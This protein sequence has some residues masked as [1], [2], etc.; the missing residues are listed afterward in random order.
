KKDGFII[1]ASECRFGFGKSSFRN[2][3]I[4]LKEKGTKVF[5]DSHRTS[6]TFES[7]QW[8]VQEFTKVFEKTKNILLLSSLTK[9]DQELTFARPIKSLN[10]G[11]R[12]ATKSIKDPFIVAI[13]EG[14][15]VV[16]RIKN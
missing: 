9:S 15:Y 8:E 3:M 2:L 1:M 5:L 4:E 13:P 11:V 16:G 14:P 10:E 6:Q 7:D 12:I